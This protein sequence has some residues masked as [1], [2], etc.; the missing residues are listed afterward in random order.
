MKKIPKGLEGLLPKWHKSVLDAIKRLKL[1][2]PDHTN[3]FSTT[4]LKKHLAAD[5]F[6]KFCKFTY[7]QS[8]LI[9]Y[10]LG[11]INFTHDVIN[12]LEYIRYSKRSCD[13]VY[14]QRYQVWR[15]LSSK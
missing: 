4:L 3:G 15:D 7:G 12:A 2:N 10:G 11:T 14:C 8:R 1:P 9:V 13:C 5:E 6:K